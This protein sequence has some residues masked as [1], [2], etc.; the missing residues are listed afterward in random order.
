M[1]CAVLR[2]AVVA[3]VFAVVLGCSGDDQTPAMADGTDPESVTG[4]VTDIEDLVPV[5]GGVMI[6][7]QLANGQMDKAFLPS[8]FTPTPPPPEQNEVYQVIQQLSIGDR[9]K[10]AGKRTSQGLQLQKLMV[11]S[12]GSLETDQND[13]PSPK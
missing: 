4:T 9:V 12:H 3:L 11:L 1:R 13:S 6:A 2:H 8:F 10:A 5:D 7:L